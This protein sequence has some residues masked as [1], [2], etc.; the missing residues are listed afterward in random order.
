[1]SLQAA[2]E[3]RR[4]GGRWNRTATWWDSEYFSRSPWTQGSG[5]R[6][7][8]RGSSAP[9]LTNDAVAPARRLIEASRVLPGTATHVRVRAASQNHYRFSSRGEG[10]L[11]CR[12]QGS[13]RETRGDVRPSFAAPIRER[14]HRAFA[15]T[16]AGSGDP[17]VP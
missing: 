6:R 5:A 4:R 3:V 17:L 9:R 10:Q 12:W 2:G 11:G 1:M 14:Y 8:W 7:V 16:N 15:L 13:S